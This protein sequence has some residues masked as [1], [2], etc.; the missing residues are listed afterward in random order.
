[1]KAS[2]IITIVALIFSGNFV[3]AQGDLCSTATPIGSLPSPGACSG[4]L[5]DGAVVST[6]GTTVG[7]TADNPYIYQTRSFLDLLQLLHKLLDLIQPPVQTLQLL[8]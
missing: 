7:S 8:F 5:Q 3:S 6:S 4:G 1:M 2:R